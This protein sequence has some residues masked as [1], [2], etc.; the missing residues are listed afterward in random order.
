MQDENADG[1]KTMRA[2]YNNYFASREYDLRYPEPNSSTMDFL[3]RHGATR[4]GSVLDVGCGN[5]RK[6]AALLFIPSWSSYL[7]IIVLASSTA[8]LIGVP[9][10]VSRC[11]TIVNATGDSTMLIPTYLYASLIFFLVCY[12]LTVFLRKVRL[13]LIQVLHCGADLVMQPAATGRKLP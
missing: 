7:L 5:G 13:D 3:R 10:L 1:T 9:E 11:N 2:L 4:S 8:S 12:P 6:G